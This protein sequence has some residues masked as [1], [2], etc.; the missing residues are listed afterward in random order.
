MVSLLEMPETTSTMTASQT[1]PAPKAETE[2]GL[3]EIEQLDFAYGNH[4]V[5]HDVNLN[6]RPPSTFH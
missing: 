3:I 1:T 4:H 5:L 2:P 6:I